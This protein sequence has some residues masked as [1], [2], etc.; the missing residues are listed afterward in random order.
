[1]ARYR[2]IDQKIWADE[3]FRS[4]SPIP[5]CGQGLWL[6]L[7]TGPSCTSIP[8][9]YRAGPASLAE[10]LGWPMK[11]FLEA[12]GEVLSQGIVEADWKARVIWI[13]NAFKFNVPE[14]PNVVLSWRV[15]WEEIPECNLKAVA[16]ERL[17]GFLE[18]FDKAF[19]KAFDKACRKPLAKA[20]AKA[21]ANQEQEPEQEPKQEHKQEKGSASTSKEVS[22]EASPPTILSKK[23]KE[24]PPVGESGEEDYIEG[25]EA[26]IFA[27]VSLPLNGGSERKIRLSEVE[28]WCRL[29]PAVDVNCEIGKMRGWCLGNSTRRK[30]VRGVDRFIHSWLARA[31]DAAGG[32]GLARGAMTG[33]S[34]RAARNQEA[35]ETWLRAKEEQDA[36]KRQG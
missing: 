21:M 13:P 22:S 2:K 25:K 19:T 14:S 30:T 10:E 9:L 20:M 5:P 12:F 4:L 34:G 1:M 8:G 3:K 27:A 36:R 29:Y 18:D 23:K 35:A 28:E 16:W 17:R 6:Y 26:T 7:L 11:A 33:S 24:K 31:Q 32:S 15:A